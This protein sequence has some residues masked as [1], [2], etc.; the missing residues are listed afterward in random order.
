MN[1]AHISHFGGN[2]GDRILN[3]AVER[4]WEQTVGEP[5]TWTQMEVQRYFGG[6]ETIARLSQFDLILVGGGGLF[7]PDTNANDNSG[8]EWNI[9]NEDLMRIDAPIAV[10][11]IG[12]NFFR[13]QKVT[14]TFIKGMKALVKKAAFVGLRNSGSIEALSNLGIDTSS[15]HL[16]PCPTTFTAT[17]YPSMRH[18]KRHNRIGVC[19]PMDRAA[20]RYGSKE[21]AQE[22]M[23][24][25]SAACKILQNKGY[26]IRLFTHIG[27]DHRIKNYL[28]DVGVEY[29]HVDLDALTEVEQGLQYYRKCDM[30]IS[31]RGHSSMAPFG[32]GVPSIAIDNHDKMRFFLQDAEAEDWLLPITP[33]SK[34][35]TRLLGK[36]KKMLRTYAYQVDHIRARQ[37]YFHGLTKQNIHA[38]LSNIGD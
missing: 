10:F 1:I 2:W 14:N 31:G 37:E 15:V 17:M 28:G 26:S 36:A 18:N 24:S 25:V 20:L 23:K 38:I 35:S 4:V 7:L 29:D 12:Y 27:P 11:A 22:V 5:I 30:V 3:W 6:E 33:K 21:Y 19:F 9:P 32:I 16:Q 13:G 8:W 34:L